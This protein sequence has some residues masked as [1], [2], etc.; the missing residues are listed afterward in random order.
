M[1]NSTLVQREEFESLDSQVHRPCTYDLDA[2]RGEKGLEPTWVS[3]H[4]TRQAEES[5][6]GIVAAKRGEKGPSALPTQLESK[7][8][9]HS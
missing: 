6:T 7:Q 4:H 5:D 3:P 9:E 8:R 1:M 2:K